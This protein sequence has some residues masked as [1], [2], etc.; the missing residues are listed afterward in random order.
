MSLA[1]GAVSVSGESMGGDIYL[2][3]ITISDSC[4]S[5]SDEMETVQKKIPDKDYF[6]EQI[7]WAH[8]SLRKT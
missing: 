7:V 8:V 3:D 6:P 1:I 2:D 4:L 5:K